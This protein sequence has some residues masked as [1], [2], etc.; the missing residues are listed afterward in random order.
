MDDRSLGASPCFRQLRSRRFFSELGR[1]IDGLPFETVG[2]DKVV[3]G[4]RLFLVMVLEVE[5]S[6][7]AVAGFEA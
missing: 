7:K 3:D 6:N 4:E 1:S 2:V 5:I